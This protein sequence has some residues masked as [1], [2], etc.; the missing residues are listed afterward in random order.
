[1]NTF[2]HRYNAGLEES[3]NIGGLVSEGDL[4]TLKC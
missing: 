3:L 2:K 4:T 1:M